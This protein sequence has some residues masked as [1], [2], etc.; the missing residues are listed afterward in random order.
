M[1]SRLSGPELKE[2]LIEALINQGCNVYDCGMCTTPAMFMTTILEDYYCDGSIMITASH[3]PYYYNGLKFFTKEGGCEK[4]DIADIIEYS[5]SVRKNC[6]T[7]GSI[8]KS[9]FYRCVFKYIN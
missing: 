6:I 8:T 7:R 4:E 5:N 3:L 1:D 9:R 2:V